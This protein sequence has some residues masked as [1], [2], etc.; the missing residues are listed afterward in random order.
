MAS[1]PATVEPS[2]LGLRR[3]GLLE[4]L[5]EAALEQL[6]RQSR[7]RRFPPAQRVISRDAQDQDVYL[8]VSG[9]VRV[10]SFSAAGRQVTFRDIPGGDW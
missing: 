6:A 10:T 2:I 4:G 7:W 3:I 1:K 5:P 9:R 8:I